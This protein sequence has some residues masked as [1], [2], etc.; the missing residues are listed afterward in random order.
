MVAMNPALD[1]LLEHGSWLRGLAASLIQDATAVDDVV[2]ETYLAALKSPP[3]TTRPVRPWLRFVLRNVV[4]E[5]HRRDQRRLRR[6]QLRTASTGI[7]TSEEIVERVELQKVLAEEVAALREPYRNAI[8]L[9]YFEQKSQAEVAQALGIPEST[10]RTRLERARAQLRERLD[11]RFGD[12]RA[13]CLPL[14]RIAN[15]TAAAA[16]SSSALVSLVSMVSMAA[17]V[18]VGIWVTAM[19]LPDHGGSTPLS[20]LTTFESAPIPRSAYRLSKD[21]GAV[22]AEA[23]DESRREFSSVRH[24]WGRLVREEDGT[25]VA[26]S[27]VIALG[28]SGPDSGLRGVTWTDARGDFL[29][30]LTPMSPDEYAASW[31]KR[32]RS[33]MAHGLEVRSESHARFFRFPLNPGGSPLEL[34]S[35]GGLDLGTVVVHRGTRVFGRVQNR[36]GA[37]VA[38]A[39]LFIL[40]DGRGSSDLPPGLL[41]EVGT[42]AADGS[43]AL[44]EP[45]TV[46][47]S[48]DSRELMLLASSSEGLGWTRMNL[49][50]GRDA[51]EL[52][53]VVGRATLRIQVK[54]GRGQPLAGASVRLIPPFS[55]LTDSGSQPILQHLATVSH[56]L[57][58]WESGALFASTN[59][60]GLAVLDGVPIYGDH[61]VYQALVAHDDCQPGR[62]PIALTGV[63]PQVEQVQLDLLQNVVVWGQVTDLMGSP[64]SQA[65]VSVTNGDE[66]STDARGLYRVPVGLE[67]PSTV[68]V[69]VR[70]AGFAQHIGHIFVKEPKSAVRQDVRLGPPAPTTIWVVDIHGRPVADLE[71]QLSCGGGQALTPVEQGGG[72]FVFDDTIQVEW[73]LAF[74]AKPGQATDWMSNRGTT[75]M[76]GDTVRVVLQKQHPSRSDLIIEMTDALTGAPLDAEGSLSWGRVLTELN[77]LSPSEGPSPPIHRKAGRLQA[78]MQPG[79]WVIWVRVK[80]RPLSWHALQVGSDGVSIQA[81][82]L[83]GRGAVVTGQVEGVD[84]DARV[85]SV[86]LEPVGTR[87]PPAPWAGAAAWGCRHE[88]PH[89]LPDFCFENVPMGR[90]RLSLVSRGQKLAE[91]V[92]DV[93][94][95]GE[96]HF[97]LKPVSDRR[98]DQR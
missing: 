7:L 42:A 15:P 53:V 89:V 86:S 66:V 67:G 22:R 31:L 36:S 94:A 83:I 97:L 55:A 81:N 59:E 2:Q 5:R 68:I 27:E 96:L 90:F 63:V 58:P 20:R 48:T 21:V 69:D 4:R 64:V 19:V 78:E 18:L 34:S 46:K 3:D 49:L 23:Q 72:C 6:E 35:G 30:E 32:S 62:F 37:G 71:P 13:W 52:H 10:L 40:T 85:T 79:E 47:G 43:F 70:A 80:D 44:A 39:R 87:A 11:R 77:E 54:D 9:L 82:L 26:G 93:P 29:L 1:D 25:P 95:I 41:W 91:E 57:D 28:R 76:G 75:V 50:E 73:D 33:Y 24:M 98:F 8:V 65:R 56:P 16:S 88:T 14:I 84:L 17:V 12:R 45:V 38:G 51:Q 61:L 60:F 92:V 74:V